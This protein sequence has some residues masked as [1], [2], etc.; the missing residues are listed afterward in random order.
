MDNL[1]IKADFRETVGTG[2]ARAIRRAGGVPCVIYSQGKEAKAISLSIK[3]INSICHRFDV[4]TNVVNLEIDGKVRKALVKQISVHPVTDQIEHVDFVDIEESI[5]LRVNVPIK[6]V[7]KEKSI[8]IKRGGVV[9]MAKRFLKCEVN[10]DNVPQS[11]I[12]DVSNIKMGS[13]FSLKDV[14][15]PSGV[16]LVYK[17][18]DQ[19]ILKVTG[20]RSKSMLEEEGAESAEGGD[21]EETDKKEEENS[22]K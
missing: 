13:P 15:L 9:N 16:K 5:S 20:K 21:E 7:G 10:K 2:A 19:T 3:D 14:N 22:T 8:E 11:I 12:I 4:M 17:D 18:L 1:A 6:I